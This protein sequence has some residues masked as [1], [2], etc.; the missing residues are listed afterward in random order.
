MSHS[1][2]HV[3]KGVTP[4]AYLVSANDLLT[5]DVVYLTAHGSWSVWLSEAKTYRQNEMAVEA[6]VYGNEAHAHLV[7]GAYVLAIGTDGLPL[8]TKERLRA[9]GPSNYFHGKQE[10]A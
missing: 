5:G 3:I 4:A 10:V 9:Q 8:S 2:P 7:V 6:A 1:K